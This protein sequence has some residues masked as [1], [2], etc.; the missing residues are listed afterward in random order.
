MVNKF[1]K[2]DY[3]TT[4][5]VID[6]QTGLRC[7]VVISTVK[8]FVNE[9]YSAN[10]KS[11]ASEI[12]KTLL[13]IISTSNGEVDIKQYA[14]EFKKI[15]KLLLDFGLI[16]RLQTNIRIHCHYRGSKFLFAS[17][18]YPFDG[19]DRNAVNNTFDIMGNLCYSA[20]RMCVFSKDGQLIDYGRIFRDMVFDEG[21]L[22]DIYIIDYTAIKVATR[23]LRPIN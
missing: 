20:R 11:I 10:L 8:P 9:D 14:A 2:L 12:A 4:F 1:N 21:N 5:N 6:M 16:S 15:Q 23:H 7:D 13:T 18:L 22:R 19:I 17:V 3:S